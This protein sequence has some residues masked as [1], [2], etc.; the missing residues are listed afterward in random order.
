MSDFLESIQNE[1]RR[2]DSKQLLEIIQRV[3]GSEA[4]IWGT[5]IIGFGTY[6]HKRENG[7][8]YEW[9]RVGFSPGK[10]RLTLYLMYDINEELE[11]LEQLGP[12]KAGKSCIFINELGDMNLDVLEKIIG[13]ND[14]WA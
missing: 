6:A 9:F 8:E 5:G 1:Q 2:E 13:K 12:H 14:R 7:E 4:T 3:T 10:D 11:L